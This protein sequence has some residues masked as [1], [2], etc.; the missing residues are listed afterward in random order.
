[1]KIATHD[2]ATGERSKNLL[3]SLFKF[4]AQTQDKTI[5]EQYEAGVRY[6][7]LRIDKDLVLCHGLWKSGKNLADILMEMRKYVDDITYI[8]VTIERKY[9]D[10]VCE[11]LIKKIRN[12]IN[13]HG[14][15]VKLVHVAKKKPSWTILKEYRHISVVYGYISVPTFKQYLT[16]PFKDWRR[17]VPIPKFLKRITPKKEFSDEYYVMVD[18]V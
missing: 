2:S 8:T 9:D 16:R 12:L 15:K 7:D 18:F 10:A 3:H 5:K 14:K 17:Y 13:L 11:E 6:F 1:M 4:F